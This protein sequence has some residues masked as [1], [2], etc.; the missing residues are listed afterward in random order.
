MPNLF[1]EGYENETIT[2]D[3]IR[4]ADAVGYKNGVA[5]DHILGDF[6][7]DG[8][9]QLMDCNGVE[10]W[11][12]WCINCIETERY[13]HLAYSTDF[14]VEIETAMKAESRGLAENILTRQ[15]V[16]AIMADPYKR[17]EYVEKVKYDW[18]VPDAVEINL[19]IKGK[20]DVTI[21][22]TAYITKGAI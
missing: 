1:P 21:D 6:L 14:G 16:E 11:K 22:I 3:D 4:P 10:S 15:I 18:S 19:V 13:K 20:N 9:N 2:P 7:R 17:T 12:S 5:F 8:K